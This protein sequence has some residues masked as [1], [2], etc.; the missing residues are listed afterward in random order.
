MNF[1]VVFE[2]GNFRIA[3]WLLNDSLATIRQ[4]EFFPL[5]FSYTTRAANLFT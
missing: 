1:D 5:E 4:G 3:V 2:C